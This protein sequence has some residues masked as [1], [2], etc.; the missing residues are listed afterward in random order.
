[1]CWQVKQKHT[2]CLILLLRGYGDVAI[3]ITNRHE[4]VCATCHIR[5]EKGKTELGTLWL[6][7]ITIKIKHWMDW[8]SLGC[9]AFSWSN[10]PNV[11]SVLICFG[12]FHFSLGLVC[13]YWWLG[14][15][16]YFAGHNFY[17]CSPSRCFFFVFTISI[18]G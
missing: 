7:R 14:S 8:V 13:P 15:L 12:S 5:A 11:G 4:R 18:L 17:L 2:C 9:V 3:Y 6:L 10:V 16:S 1:M